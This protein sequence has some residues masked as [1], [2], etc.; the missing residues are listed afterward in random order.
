MICNDAN[1][2]E[3]AR[4]LAA[5]GAALLF[6]PLNNAL[7][8]D[9]AAAWRTRTRSNLIARAVENHLTVIAADVAGQLNERISYGGTAIVGPDGALL[10]EAAPLVEG[11]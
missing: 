7:R 5:R 8:P 1:Y 11:S 9:I 4:V 10:A 2:L 6:M 3:P